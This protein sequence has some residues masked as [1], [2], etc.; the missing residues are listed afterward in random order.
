MPQETNR[1]RPDAEVPSQASK[2]LSACFATEIPHRIITGFL[3]GFESGEARHDALASL[4]GRR[5]TSCFPIS[6]TG[7]LR[8]GS[9]SQGDTSH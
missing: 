6:S 7:L 8:F 4:L 2:G 3:L 1:G 9:K 5:A